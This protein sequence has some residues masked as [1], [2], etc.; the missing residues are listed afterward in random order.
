MNLIAI[1]IVLTAFTVIST[2]TNTEMIFL[3]RNPEYY[4]IP[5]A[6]MGTI[7]NTILFYCVLANMITTLFV[8]QIYDIVGRKLS[9]FISTIL[10]AVFLILVPYSPSI[11]PW[12]IVTRIGIAISSVSALC[13]PLVTDYVKKSSRGKATAF[14][15]MGIV[16]GD[17]ITYGVIFTITK[18]MDPKYSF[19]FTS[20]ITVLFAFSFLVIIKEPDMKKIH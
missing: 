6:E 1:P 14:Q 15:T 8:G 4:N 18:D 3:L 2:F 11:Y 19:L 13:L 16:I 20:M 17:L 5:Q 10:G 7:T 9:L 12:V